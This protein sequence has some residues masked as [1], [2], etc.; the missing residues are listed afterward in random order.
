MAGA[1]WSSVCRGVERALEALTA[2]D[3]VT[4][5]TFN[6]SVDVIPPRRVGSIDRKRALD[7]TRTGGGTA[8]YDASRLGLLAG[9]KEHSD[10]VESAR[11]SGMSV[12]T[13]VVIM[14]GECASNRSGA[15]ASSDGADDYTCCRL[16]LQMVTTPDLVP[17]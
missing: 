15:L 4:I 8:L 12:H 13:H 1:R 2:S 5:I 3:F 17:R 14:T 9:L 10:L 6:E 7:G 11:S 16:A